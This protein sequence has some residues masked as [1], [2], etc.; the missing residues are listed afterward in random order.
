MATSQDKI[1]IISETPRSFCVTM[2]RTAVIRIANMHSYLG[3]GPQAD[4]RC[5]FVPVGV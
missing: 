3:S 5:Q 1:A 2:K 4:G